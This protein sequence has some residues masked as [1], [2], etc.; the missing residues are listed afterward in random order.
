MVAGT[1]PVRT[2]PDGVDALMSLRSRAA[3]WCEDRRDEDHPRSAWLPHLYENIYFT[4]ECYESVEISRQMIDQTR[5]IPT[6]VHKEDFAYQC[7]CRAALAIQWSGPL[8]PAVGLNTEQNFGNIRDYS[9]DT[10][11]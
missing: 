9:H 3:R 2:P 8:G 11:H 6:L 4:E 10:R 5:S 1:S 7:S